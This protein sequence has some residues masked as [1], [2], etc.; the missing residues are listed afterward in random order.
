MASKRKLFY[1]HWN[2]AE[3]V[4]R[5]VP[6]RKAGFRVTTHSSTDIP[7]TLKDTPP[8]VAVISLDRL[9]SHG[10]AVAEW[11]WDSGRRHIPIIF[12][13]G[14]PDKVELTRAKFPDATYA[15]TGTVPDVLANLPAAVP[16]SSDSKARRTNLK[17]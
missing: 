13:G 7:P 3:V 16:E 5:V 4:A 12:E 10:R 1:L 17:K 15:P 14:D 11:L 6:L 2:E 8:D 9:P